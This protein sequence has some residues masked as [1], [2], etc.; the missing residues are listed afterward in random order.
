[1][2]ASKLQ[3]ALCCWGSQQSPPPSPTLNESLSRDQDPI[4]CSC[5]QHVSSSSLDEKS[6]TPNSNIDRTTTS[7]ATATCHCHSN[8]NIN[9]NIKSDNTNDIHEKLSS[10]PTPTSIRRHSNNSDRSPRT[11]STTASPRTNKGYLSNN[12]SKPASSRFSLQKYYYPRNKM[13]LSM[14][15]SSLSPPASPSLAP[16]A[17]GSPP[18]TSN[19]SKSA[20]TSF[21]R[22]SSG[23]GP[24]PPVAFAG[25]RTLG[26]IPDSTLPTS[27]PISTPPMPSTPPLSPPAELWSLPTTSISGF[28]SGPLQD[29]PLTLAPD[30][31]VNVSLHGSSL[32]SNEPSSLVSPL[33][34]LSPPPPSMVTIT[35]SSPPSSPS[36]APSLSLSNLSAPSKPSLSLSALTSPSTSSL[37]S[38]LSESNSSS[39]IASPLK[40]DLIPYPASGISPADLAALLAR[41]SRSNE[42]H[43]LRPLVLDLRPNP[44]FELLSILHSININLPTLLM[45]RYRR[46]GAVSSFALESFITMPSDKD[47]YDS[48]QD[49]WRSARG[50]GDEE[51][52]DVIVLDQDMRAGKEEFGRSASPA[53]TLVNVLERGGGNCGGPLR[54]WYLEGGFD[55]FQA[56]DTGANFLVYPGSTCEASAM[57]PPQAQD[58]TLAIKHEGQLVSS[59]NSFP[60]SPAPLSPTTPSSAISDETAQ[61]INNAVSLTNASL[62]ASPGGRRGAPVRRESLFSLNTKSLQRPAGLNRAQ[63]IGVSAINIKPLTIPPINNQE[64]VPQAP[65]RHKASWLTVPT[66]INTASANLAGPGAHSP[67]MSINTHPMDIAQSASTDHTSTWSAN[68]GGSNFGSGNG[69]IDSSHF[70]PQSLYQSGLTS[71]RSFSSTTTLSSASHIGPSKGIQEEE[72]EEEAIV[73]T[74]Q[75]NLNLRRHNSAY[76]TKSTN[77]MAGGPGG[78]YFDLSDNKT[79]SGFHDDRK[80]N[81]PNHPFSSQIGGDCLAPM[82]HFGDGYNSSYNNHSAMVNNPPHPYDDDIM[83]EGGDN[84]EQEIS[85]ILPN[86]LFLGPEI[87]SEDQV[88]ELERLGVKRVLN[89]A[90]ECEDA[91]VQTRPGMTYFKIGVQD[92]IE[93]DVSA[94]LMQAVDIIAA[95]ADSPIYVHC[96]A[97]KSRSVTAT[98]AYLITQLHW[99]L[100]KAYNHVLTQRPCMCPN[101][102]FVTELMRMEE[103]TFGTERAGGLVRAGSLNSILSL[104][105]AGSGHTYAHHHHHHSLNL[106]SPKVLSAKNSLSNM[107]SISSLT[108]MAIVPQMH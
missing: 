103:R 98:I 79:V 33:S 30:P 40:S 67:A 84:G 52:H 88:Q 100:N 72:E 41:A 32:P 85:C 54:V 47:L 38:S 4:E 70:G 2:F 49:G 63:T 50:L 31:L 22:M 10:P 34:P 77:I 51:H 18:T 53:W 95:L 42:K 12:G 20:S 107:S 27:S 74:G 102:G 56:W 105:T 76:S 104:S 21:S 81:D 93:A 61:A 44:D 78:S 97:G 99:P 87:V 19:S 108:T 55:A 6:A 91:L 73:P 14:S 92:H 90:R 57:E 37:S 11:P 96:K 106:G 39:T 89:M 101:I 24:L 69:N 5:R 82:N 23:T 83:D 60:S 16:P 86:F 15:S 65:L 62:G 48:I 13:S 64:P 1:M 43:N 59:P 3:S 25:P 66:A 80:F 46:G 7:S 17:P 94:G 26:L 28:K 35:P 58:G 9:N 75:Q 45:R 36:T 29:H 68:S 71:K 8:S